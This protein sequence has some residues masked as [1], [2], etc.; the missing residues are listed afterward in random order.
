MTQ[1][2]EKTE[3]N[4][5]ADNLQKEEKEGKQQLEKQLEEIAER[6]WAGKAAVMVGAGF[7]KNAKSS[8]NNND[9]SG[10]N[11][12][13]EFLS[14]NELADIFYEEAR[15]KKPEDKDKAYLNVLTLAE[16]VKA[17][18]G[19]TALNDLLEK[20][21][22]D[23]NFEPSDLH[24]DLLKLP[25]T[26]VFTTNY[27]TL[28]E[29]ASN[30]IVLRRYTPVYNK[31]DI[32]LAEKPRIVKLHGSFPSERPF[33]ITEEDYRRYP[34]THA[35]FVNTVRQVFLENIICLIGFSGNDPNFLSWI[36]WI[37]DNFE[38]DEN[39][40]NIRDNFEQD[41][42]KKSPP[43]NTS[44]MPKIYLIGAFKH[45]HSEKKLL[46]NRGI[47]VVDLSCFSEKHNEALK[48]FF[49]KMQERNPYTLDWP[50]NPNFENKSYSASTEEITNEWRN[51]RKSYPGWLILPYEN[52]K[53]LWEET[54]NQLTYLLSNFSSDNGL[55]IQYLDELI[56]RLEKC[57]LPLSLA[58]KVTDWCEKV[59]E[60]YWPFKEDEALDNRKIYYKQEEDQPLPL[61]SNKEAWIRISLSMLRFHR[62]SGNLKKLEE[63]EKRLRGFFED[64]SPE[65]KE[66]LDYERFLY[67]LFTL[68]LSEAKKSLEEW[69][70][71]QPYWRAKRA[72]AL[73]EIGCENNTEEKIRLALVESRKQ[74]NTNNTAKKI[75]PYS[76]ESYLMLLLRYINKANENIGY[77]N[78]DITFEEMEKY[79]YRN[80]EKLK[81]LFVKSDK[82]VFNILDKINQRQKKYFEL[83]V[84]KKF[85]TPKE[86]WNDLKEKYNAERTLHWSTLFEAFKNEKLANDIR[87]D[88]IR[89]DQLR[90]AYRSRKSTS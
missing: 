25:W 43:N 34:K 7:S 32:P 21:L 44:T 11:R 77:A 3:D 42:N 79:F 73:A 1:D 2:I 88:N 68:N 76:E 48:K 41:K 51:Q 30:E 29:Q 26:D 45:S 78:K 19:K 57:L 67:N 85:K 60:N 54:K 53:K 70:S 89:W 12:T 28:L 49:K 13:D 22:P 10:N 72:A 27:D 55:D 23:Q 71:E 50:N 24:K 31:T 59:L 82:P 37:R 39:N 46:K 90:A 74:G 61:A 58:P 18:K 66:S 84:P 38:Q 14:W 69:N 6:L 8:A 86:D 83:Y 33:I 75:P 65:Q 80:W 16:E 35:P 36:G 4:G 63:T 9:P 40:E 64:L 47:T 62:E 56:W 15:G 5:Q 87:Q 52:R 20:H 81:N 17:Y